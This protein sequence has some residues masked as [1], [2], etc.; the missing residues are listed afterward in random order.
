[1]TEPAV[2][3]DHPPETLLK[4]ANPALRVLL[5]TPLAGPLGKQL[6]VLNFKGRKSGRPFSIPVSAHH[7]DGDLY[8][9]ANAGWKHN[10]TGGADAEVVHGGKTT[11]M[12][13][14][15]ISNPD[16]V[17]DLAHRCAQS[18]GVKK[19]QTMMG[20][21]FRDNQIP[22]LDQFKEGLAREKIVAVKFTPR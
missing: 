22:T 9:I 21:K 1:M 4:V 12:H 2:K 3:A 11:K 15:L 14:E 19:A 7:I 18:Y 17:A 13:G 6:M 8:A 5:R 16:V 10:F 20:L